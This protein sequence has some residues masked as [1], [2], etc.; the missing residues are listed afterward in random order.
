M[1]DDIDDGKEDEWQYLFAVFPPLHPAIVIWL[2]EAKMKIGILLTVNE[3]TID[4]ANLA[5]KAE[6]L[7]FESLW[8]PDHAV[9]PWHSETPLPETQPGQGGIPE[10]YSHMCDPFVAMA[11]A[12]GV[13]TRLKVGT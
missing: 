6:E 9:M 13:T 7:G 12:T 5:R 10:V 4:P 2:S 3:Y 1:I 8:L 11:I